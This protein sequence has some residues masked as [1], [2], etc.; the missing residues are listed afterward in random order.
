[1]AKY[2][3]DFNNLPAQ[4][5]QDIE[6]F[7][8]VHIEQGPVLDERKKDLGIVTDIVGLERYDVYLTGQANHAGT[9]PMAYRQDALIA[10]GAMVTQA[11]QLA[12][13]FG[14]PLVVTFGS[15]DVT[16]NMSNIVPGAVMFSIDTRHTDGVKLHDFVTQMF[17]L[18]E[19][20]ATEMKIA[21]EIKERMVEVPVAM[22]KTLVQMIETI[23]QNKGYNYQLMHSGAGH[24]SQIVGLHVPTVMLFVP[25]RHGISHHP[26]E[27]T[28]LKHLVLGVE[29]L[30]NVLY[31][32]AYK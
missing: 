26:S 20:I 32:L 1:M 8:E 28:E 24:D 21:L 12:K 5:K 13:E 23:F 30:K 2:C 11:T 6:A 19:T 18:F 31:E 22:D 14:D 25:S 29:A 7:I 15:L 4:A 17:T 10:F 9:T 3:Y 27:F 16:P